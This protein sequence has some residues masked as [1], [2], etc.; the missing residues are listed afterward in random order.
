MELNDPVF[1]KCNTNMPIRKAGY[2]Q[3]IANVLWWCSV[4]QS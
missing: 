4:A 2:I 1:K 3:N